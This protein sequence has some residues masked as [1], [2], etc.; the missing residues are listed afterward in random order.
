M[1]AGRRPKVT[2]L[3]VIEG[4]KHATRHKNRSKE[5][6]AMGRLPDAPAWFSPTR[7]AR[8]GSTG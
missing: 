3:H 2:R 6:V 1:T 4:V 8:C 5:P 7:S